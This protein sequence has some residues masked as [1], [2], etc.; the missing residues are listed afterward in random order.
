MSTNHLFIPTVLLAL[1][2]NHVQ[3]QDAASNDGTTSDKD[4]LLGVESSSGVKS[5]LEKV[6][7]EQILHS[8]SRGVEAGER[9]KIEAE[10]K[11]EPTKDTFFGVRVDTDPKKN[12]VENQTNK[13]ELTMGSKLADFEIEVD[14]DVRDG[15]S[16]IGADTDSSGTFVRYNATKNLAFT[17]YPFNFGGDLGDVFYTRD[18]AQIYYIEGEPSSIPQLPPSEREIN[19]DVVIRTKSLAGI[20]VKYTLL[21]GLDLMAGVGSARYL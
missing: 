15:L 1:T 5:Y 7:Y 14:L 10:F 12:S 13:F 17:L 20:D 2:C 21:P 4:A 18:A 6:E 9:A 16:T 11:V 19:R 3:A 8:S